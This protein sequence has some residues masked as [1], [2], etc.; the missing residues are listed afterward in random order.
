MHCDD[1]KARARKCPL[2]HLLTKGWLRSHSLVW[3]NFFEFDLETGWAVCDRHRVVETPPYTKQLNIPRRSL[4]LWQPGE[5]RR[6][7]L[8]VR[9]LCTGARYFLCWSFWPRQNTRLGE[10]VLLMAED[11]AGRARVCTLLWHLSPCEIPLERSSK[12]VAT[13]AS[14][15]AEIAEC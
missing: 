6:V 1:G 4:V 9:G 3:G 13:S 2:C 15:T 12:I 8:T 10:N 11:A 7:W 14:P 5:R